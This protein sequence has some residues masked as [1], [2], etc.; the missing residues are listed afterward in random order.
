MEAINF[1]KEKLKMAFYD[2]EMQVRK[3]VSSTISMIIVKGG[4]NIWPDVLHF[5][6][7]NLQVQDQTIVENS[8]LAISII[9]E[10]CDSLFE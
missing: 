9:V 3:T 8:I 1:I 6:T 4:I 2:P 5:L 7:D 10:D